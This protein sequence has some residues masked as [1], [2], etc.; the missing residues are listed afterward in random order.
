MCTW[1]AGKVRSEWR[2]QTDHMR[3]QINSIMLLVLDLA[4]FHNTKWVSHHL[5]L[6]RSSHSEVF[7]GKGV[8][9]ICVKVTG[10]H[11]CRSVISIKLQSNFIKIT[12]WHGCSQVNLLHIFRTAFPKNTSGWLLLSDGQLL[13]NIVMLVFAQLSDEIFDILLLL[14]RLDICSCFG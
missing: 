9:K 8:L 11:P 6:T 4:K 2:T 13:G 10:E 12:F 3:R 1:K 14:L 5:T 7:W